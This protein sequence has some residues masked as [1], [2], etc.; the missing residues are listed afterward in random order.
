MAD[1]LA[2][3]HMDLVKGALIS[4][5]SFLAGAATSAIMINWARRRR[6]RHEFQRHSCWWRS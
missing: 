4:V 3:G 1:H 5:L 6:S 2:L